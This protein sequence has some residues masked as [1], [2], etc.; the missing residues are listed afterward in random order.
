MIKKYEGTMTAETPI[1][2]GGDEKTG[3]SPIL[4]SITM[5]IPTYG[6]F[7]PIPFICGNAT[8][9]KLRR[10]LM[11][12]FCDLLEI[13]PEELSTKLYHI[14]FTGGALESTDKT[15]GLIDL[16]LRQKIRQLLPP[17]AL[18]G[19][20]IGNQMIPGKLKVGHAFPICEE[21]A[22]FLPEELKKDERAKIPVRTFTDES[23][24]TR[25]DD[26]HAERAEDEQAT[27]MKVT[28]ECFVPGTTF[29][30]WW[31]LEYPTEIESSC[32]GHLMNLFAKSPF[33]GGN[34][35]T[36][37]GKVSFSY[38][39]DFPDAELYLNFIKENKQKITDFLKELEERV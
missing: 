10:L 33:I 4:R 26:L 11:K 21:Y 35:A 16:A 30:H 7:A 36:G 29:F 37:Y 3:S 19:A 31:A 22:Q 18:Y 12:N 8:R 38:K 27:Q 24:Q 2:H 28:F 23:S 14:F 25:R 39:P 5:F 13:N 20:A 9:G 15:S 32:F 34:S 6:T 17:V 1:F